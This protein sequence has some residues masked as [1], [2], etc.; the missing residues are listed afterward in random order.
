MTNAS[1]LLDALARLYARAG[2]P[3]AAG[4]MLGT[5]LLSAKSCTLDE[6]ALELH[7]SKSAASANAR[8]LEAEGAVDRLQQPGDRHSYFFAS[9]QLGER[10][11]DG[12]LR[13][14]EA[15]GE[16]FAEASRGAVA[17]DPVADRFARILEVNRRIQDALRQ[18]RAELRVEAAATATSGESG[19]PR[20]EPPV[21]PASAHS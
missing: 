19:A 6:L 11:L 5:L 10:H 16:C 7:I 3:P 1:D 20:D 4:R 15:L 17:G 8:L 13:S 2:H 12:Y 9:A 14:V 18:L 21:P